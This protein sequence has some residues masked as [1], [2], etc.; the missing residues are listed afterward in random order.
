MSKKKKTHSQIHSAKRNA[1]LYALHRYWIWSNTLR[2]KFVDSLGTAA[3]KIAN[4]EWF[5]SENAVFMSYWYSSLYAVVEGYKEL[6]LSDPAVDALLE[7][8]LVDSL[9]LYRNGT[10][11]F[12]K[13]YFSDKFSNLISQNDSAIWATNLCNAL[14]EYIKNELQRRQL[15]LQQQ[16]SSNT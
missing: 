9:R 15:Q 14:G 1:E 10:A 5:V 11:H 8:E 12:Q 7:S 13:H 4:R 16:M 3:E 6:K 2:M